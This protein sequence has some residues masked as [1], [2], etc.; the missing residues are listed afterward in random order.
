MQRE[1]GEI[2]L[3]LRAAL[4]CEFSGA[5][6]ADVGGVVDW[7]VEMY[8]ICISVFCFCS[9]G[10]KKGENRDEMANTWFAV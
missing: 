4:T 9:G 8:V 10:G 1:Q 6:A 5:S 7:W 2:P 3:Q